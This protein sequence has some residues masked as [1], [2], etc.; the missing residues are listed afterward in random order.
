M[1][2]PTDFNDLAQIAGAEAVKAT[3][4]KVLATAAAATVPPTENRRPP[5]DSPLTPPQMRPEGFP[6]LL[7]EICDAACENSEAHPVA[8]AFNVLLFFCAMVGRT[9]FQRIGDAVIHC[10][11][12]GIIAG[13][14]GKARKG[15]SETLVRLLFSLVDAKLGERLK[16]G[17][18]L[19]IHAGG[20]STG[21]GI[22]HAIRDAKEA[23]DKGKGGDPGVADKR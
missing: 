1:S 21:E 7:K 3:V 20:L 13:K 9:A 5:D 23:D 2:K 14:S 12:F 19:R 4:D 17:A 16:T 6:P 11:V 8:V 10:R 18:R 22:A 15:T